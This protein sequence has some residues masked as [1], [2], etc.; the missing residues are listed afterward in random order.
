MR[1]PVG[2][3]AQPG[4][5]KRNKTGTWRTQ[6][7][8]YLHKTCIDCKFCVIYCPDGCVSGEKK[9]YD[10]NL[11]YCKGCGICVQVCPVDDIQMAPE[12]R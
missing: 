2:F 11:D 1:L 7:P 9:V 5:S 12:V 3:Y 4:T 6:R 8:V 10:A